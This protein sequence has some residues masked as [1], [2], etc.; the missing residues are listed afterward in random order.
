M[1]A[2]TQP[3]RHK[4]PTCGAPH[5][6][7]CDPAAVALRWGPPYF[8]MGRWIVT[9]RDFLEELEGLPLLAQQENVLAG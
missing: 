9:Y 3:L 8:H 7:L 4:C 2:N 1:V 6:D 5:G